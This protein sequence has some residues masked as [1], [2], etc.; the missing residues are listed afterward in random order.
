[1]ATDMKQKESGQVITREKYDALLFD[2]DGVL[3]DTANLHAACWKK[4]FDAFLQKHADENDIPFQPFDIGKDYRQYVDGRLRYEGVRSFL[5]SRGIRLPQGEPD[6]L[7]GYESITGLGNLKDRM[8]KEALRSEGIEVYEGSVSFIRHMRREGFKTAVV[9]ASE[10]CK[11]V[12]QAAGIEDLFD[13]R[14]DGEVAARLNLPG[15]PAP[16]TFLEAAKELGSRPERAVVFED[17]LSGIQAGRDGGFGLVVGIEHHGNRQALEAH[18]ADIVV[19][20]LRELIGTE[21][22]QA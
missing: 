22:L 3:T 1:M 8:V 12:L 6:D 5:E 7:P 18:G 16:D 9:S 19:R 10:N 2:L 11:A 4:M 14:V 21:D 17:A 15:K 20:D 13:A